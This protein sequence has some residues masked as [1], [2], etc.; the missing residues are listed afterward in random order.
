MSD[1]RRIVPQRVFA[2]PE[3]QLTIMRLEDHGSGDFHCHDFHELVLIVD[4]HGKHA[5]EGDIYAIEAGDVFVVLG[6]TQHAYPEADKLSLINVLYDPDH[7]RLP[8]ADIGSLPGYHALFTVEPTLRRQQ[9]YRNR[10]RL[11]M[12]QLA[13]AL[14]IVAE[15]EEELNEARRGHRFMAIAHL[16]RLLGYLSR[17]YS[18]VERPETRPVKQISEVLGYLERHYAEPLQVADLTRIAHMSQSSLM[19]QFREIMGRSP[20][21]H[22]IRLRVS[23][24]RHLLRHTDEPISQVAL[25][26]GFSDSNYFSRQFRQVTGQS[27]RAYRQQTR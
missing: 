22:L 20:I 1:I 19:R 15:L 9:S 6:D 11:A 27:P 2:D 24:A 12:D 3:L 26:V 17:C 8:L 14:Q 13:A 25:Q 10:L 4:G 21:D 18:D 16:M 7:L 23:K 5:I